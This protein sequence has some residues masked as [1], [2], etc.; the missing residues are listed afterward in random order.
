MIFIWHVLNKTPCVCYP[1]Y[2][3]HLLM[4]LFGRKDYILSIKYSP[5]YVFYISVGIFGL[6]CIFHFSFISISSV[7]NYIRQC[8]SVLKSSTLIPSGDWRIFWMLLLTESLNLAYIWQTR[9]RLPWVSL[10]EKLSFFS[11]VFLSYPTITDLLNSC[12]YYPCTCIQ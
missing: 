7:I 8:L 3:C 4:D 2:P 9:C 5:F 6:F 11:L 10:Q 1:I 12:N